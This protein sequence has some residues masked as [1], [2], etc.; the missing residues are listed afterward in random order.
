MKI[1]AIIP[2]FNGNKYLKEAIDSVLHQSLQPI[3]LILIDD[4]STDG[5][6]EN[7]P[8][9]K[10]SF[11]IRIIKQKNA[12]QAAARNHGISLSQG[13]FIA[14]LDQDDY[15]YSNHLERLAKEFDNNDHLGWSYSNVDEWDQ[16][17]RRLKKCLLDF[18]PIDHPKTDVMRMIGEDLHILPSASLIRKKAILDVGMFDTRFS[19]Y[20]DDDL[21]LRLF[22]AGWDNAYIKTS[23]SKWRI[24]ASS[25]GHN[26]RMHASRKLFAHKV[27]ELFKDLELHRFSAMEII[28]NRFFGL[29]IKLYKN[30]LLR[31]D[32]ESCKFYSSE[33]KYYFSMLD[34]T[35]QNKWQKKVFFLRYP[36]LIQFLY[37]IKTFNKKLSI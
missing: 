2:V 26:S 11:P 33:I 37:S 9:I 12:G 4:G 17:G 1:S 35:C 28:G 16:K 36:K 22:I 13:D 19:G 32:Y 29:Y 7:L 18:I 3:E 30:S 8:E 14:L 27:I 5:S 24:H 31:K 21:F 20:E 23:L 25:S 10:A 6:I 34:K 15:W